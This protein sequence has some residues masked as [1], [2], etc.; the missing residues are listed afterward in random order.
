MH[1][2][3]QGGDLYNQE[4]WDLWH[5]RSESN[6]Q[7]FGSL[8]RDENEDGL[9]ELAHKDYENHRMSKPTPIVEGSLD[10]ATGQLRPFSLLACCISRV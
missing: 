3:D 8:R 5:S 6:S 10:E 7:L 9:H 1:Y 4:V 2:V